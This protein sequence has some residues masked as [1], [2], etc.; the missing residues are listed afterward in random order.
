MYVINDNVLDEIRDRADIVDLIGEYVDL[1]RSGSNY[2]GLC[3]FHSEKTP[4][5]SVSPSKSI[6]KC[7]GCGVG[8]DVITFVMKREN[9]SFPEA[10]EFLADKYN[11]RLEVYKDENKE[12]RE[13]RN[14][15][16]EINREAGLHFLKNYEASQKT[17]LYLKNRMLSDKTIRSYGIGYSKD[18]WTDLYDHLTKMGYRE[19]ELLELNLISK[20]KNGNYIDRFRDRVMFPIINRNN[21]IIGFGARAFGDAKPKYLNS[22]ETPIFHKGSNVFNINIISRESTRERIILV[23]GY[24]DVISL[25]NSGINYS[26]ASLG[27]SLTIDQA[28][29]IKKMARDIYICYDSDSAGINATSRAIDIFLQ[30]SV[31]PKIIELEGG[32]DPDDFIKKYGVEGFENKIKSAI[33]YIEFKIKK[34][35]ENF[36]LEDSEGLSN[37]TIES[38]KILSSIKNPIERDIFV[39]DFSRKYNISYTAIENYI[40]YLNRNKLKEAN[41]EKFKVKKNT[42]VVK[43]NKARA[44]E[45]LLSYSLLDNDIYKYIKNKI[46]VFY[47]TNAMTRAV[48]E[49][50]PRLYEEEMEVRDFLSLLES[51]RLI[52]KEFVENILSIINDIHVNDKIV[53]ELI[54]TIEGNYLRDRKNKI[55]EN[56]EKLQGEENKN[57]LLEALKELQEINLKLNELKEEGNYEW[58]FKE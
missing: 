35:K 55:L 58:K 31:K 33:S 20:S 32:L 40:N 41:R 29:I 52:D 21:R 23:E 16:Y 22:R 44:Q 3:P 34:L 48:F 1:K 8:G 47:F 39:K 15:L 2:M 25:Y 7:F 51:N 42:N 54:N 24:M 6:F 56:I 37:F 27:T 50:I 9:L 12:A 49:E 10:V 14:R 13:K 11:V 17:Q 26:I 38:S 28:N 19:D 36:N 43:S 4:S 53:D 46:E 18:S 45:E 30:A 57:L 5:F